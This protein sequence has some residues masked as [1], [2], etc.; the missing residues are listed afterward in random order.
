MIIWIK[1]DDFIYVYTT[2]GYDEKARTLRK[3]HSRAKLLQ[4]IH[5]ALKPGGL[6]IFDVFTPLQYAGRKESRSWEY[7]DEGFI[8]AEPHICLESKFQYEDTPISDA[9][10][11]SYCS[12]SNRM[13]QRRKNYS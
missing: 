11:N 9:V 12:C 10:I 7:A 6:L 1:E 13:S 5:A 2:N 3:R 4:N 8:C